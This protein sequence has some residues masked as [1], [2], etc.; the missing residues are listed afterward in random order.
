MSRFKFN[1]GWGIAIVYTTFALAT[2]TFV[3][4]ALTKDVGLVRE[5]YYQYTLEHDQRVA[6]RNAADMLG[7]EVQIEHGSDVIHIHIPRSHASTAK[8]E[9]QLYHP[10][11]PDLDRD[12]VLA[13]DASGTMVIPIGDLAIGEWKVTVT[14]KVGDTVYE[15][16]R[17]I[18]VG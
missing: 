8:G 9:V 5:D 4:F 6:A 16:E 13:V 1:W 12:L 11:D 14:W 10:S 17:R 2:L 18:P 15:E 7:D 3:F